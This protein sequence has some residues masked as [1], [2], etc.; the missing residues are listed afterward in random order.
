MNGALELPLAKA[1]ASKLSMSRAFVA[2][3]CLV[4]WLAGVPA[5]AQEVDSVDK[6]NASPASPSDA[7]DI[8]RQ[9]V[10]AYESNDLERARDLFE[11]VHAQAPTARTLRS[12]GL[13]AFRQERFADA[14]PLFEESLTSVEKPLTDAMRADVEDLLRQAREHQQGQPTTVATTPS[15]VI[16]RATPLPIESSA[17]SAPKRSS[18]QSA[19]EPARPAG[20]Q[21]PPRLKRTGYATLALAGVAAGFSGVALG[22]GLHRLDQIEGA[23]RGNPDGTCEVSEA[24]ARSHAA[25]LDLLSVLST[26]SA[27]LAGALAV[28]SAACLVVHYRSTQAEPLNAGFSLRMRF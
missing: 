6:G 11:Q 19:L 23:C 26:S 9:A 28:T 10:A 2:C 18:L 20:S 25:R 13:V 16:V 12:L 17:E 24:H 5:S 27:A 3:W 15:A 14:I 21:P 1:G 4:G 22:I 8:L 7:T